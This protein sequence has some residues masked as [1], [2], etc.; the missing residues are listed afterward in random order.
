MSIFILIFIGIV[1]I[2]ITLLVSAINDKEDQSNKSN[3]HR[4]LIDLIKS[5]FENNP[6][7]FKEG[8]GWPRYED[9]NIAITIYN[10]GSTSCTAYYDFCLVEIKDK[11][12][13]DV[14]K[15]SINGCREFFHLVIDIRAYI[16]RVNNETHTDKVTNI[17]TKNNQK[18]DM[19]DWDKQLI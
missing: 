1:A 10:R 15:I 17:I 19:E 14:V 16:E 11:E 5:K 2:A 9:K 13:G 7:L 6:E 12:T 3:K 8:D 18:T 4:L